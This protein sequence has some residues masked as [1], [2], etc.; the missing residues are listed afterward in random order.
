MRMSS[1]SELY[2][3]LLNHLPALA[4]LFVI[5]LIIWAADWWLLRRKE[6]G[7]ERRL[8]RELAI[9]LMVI[10]GVMVIIL[11]IPISDTT[12]G[13][14]FSL[15][16]IVLTGVVALSSTTFVANAMAGLMLRI[17]KSFHPGDFIRIGEQ[18]GRVTERGLLH[19]EIQTQDRDLTTLPNLYIITNP[20]TVVR[21]SG[22]IISANVSLGYDIPHDH[23]E[24]LLRQGAEQAGL[25]EPFVQV[26][27][28]GDYSVSYRVAGFLADVTQLLTARSTLRKNVMDALHGAGVEI[29]SPSF[30]NQRRLSET[31]RFIP[32]IT[33][34]KKAVSE[35][36][37]PEAIMFDKAEHAAQLE[38]LRVQHEAMLKQIDQL[39]QQR[40]TAGGESKTAIDAQIT[41]LTQ[42]ADALERQLEQP[43][44]DDSSS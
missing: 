16:G 24:A 14:I 1:F 27:E 36:V 5:V 25:Q 11:L 43:P 38:K 44:P 21:S 31:A 17:I 40:K 34:H 10:A 12:R 2:T 18:F 15:L 19:T 22:T 28:L 41:N 23:I 33:A 26:S 37:P 6:L 7:A 29:I 3:G 30:M 42:Q 32:S 13:Q 9:L 39:Q 20:V 8:P 4:A 35:E